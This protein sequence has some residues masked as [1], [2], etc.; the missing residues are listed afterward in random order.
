M[1]IKINPK[2][3]VLWKP[4]TRYILLT[5]GRG[6]AKSF[7]IGL[8]AADMMLRNHNWKMLFTRYTLSS[9]N[10]SVIPEF[11]EKLSI[12]SVEEEFNL[13]SSFIT[14][15]AT[16]SAIIFSGIKTSSGNQ[17][18]K[19]KSIPALNVFIVDEAEEF[20]DE[21]DFNTIDESIRMPNV[22][23]IVILVMNPQSVEHW[24]WKRWFEKSHVMEN[25]NGHQ[26]PIS[27]HEDL[28]HIHTTYLDNID[29]LNEDYVNKINQ[30][31]I[32]YPDAYAHR[33]LGKW[34]DKKLGVIFPN[35]IEGE[36]DESFPSGYGLDF[37]FYPDPL[38]LVKVSVD[39]KE[40]KIY[41][42]E[43]IYKQSLTYEMV[44]QQLNQL[45]EANKMIIADTSEPRLTDALQSSG[46]NVH[47]ADKG[48]GSI[49][50]G[51]KVINDYSLI[52]DSLSYN[53]KYE[54][55]NYVWNDRKS[56]TP[57]DADNHCFVGETL[58][59]TNKGLIEISKIIPNDY[60]LTSNG[61]QKV[62]IKH[63]NGK[64]QVNKYVL[65][66]DT[67]FVSLTCTNNHL[68]KTS[69][70]WKKVSELKSGMTVYL[71]KN[72]MQKNTHCIQKKGIFQ[73][74]TKE[75]T[76][77]YGNIITEKFQKVTIFITRTTTRIITQLIT[78][79]KLNP[80]NIYQNTGKEDMMKIKNG[81]NLFKKKELQPLQN[82]INQKQGLNGIE[83]M[84][85]KITLAN[86]IME[87]VHVFFAQKFIIKNQQQQNFAQTIASQL[88]EEKTKLITLK[89]NVLIAAQNTNQINT[90][91]KN[92]VAV[93]VFQIG[94]QEVYD[95]TVE[96]E[97]EYFA[98]GILVHNCIDA[99]RYVAMR[100]LQGSDLLAFN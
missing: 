15:K 52:V 85:E 2:Y 29:N 46:L 88:I 82:G 96:N 37:G 97:H 38:A 8:W 18:A 93:N 5:G 87:K 51:I 77:K 26:V 11:R 70:G 35:W 69:Q 81:L 73:E 27:S 86:L 47:K 57:I 62:L 41:I 48:A 58:V 30:M 98:N 53:L 25:I 74:A 83:N 91:G 32:D 12:L 72:L 21:R 3:E 80:Q 100:L 79:K 99:I 65:Q 33:F 34:L 84:Q 13:S 39:K 14:H 59:K 40:K 94:E 54:L 49:I 90:Q 31:A 95:L 7:T 68:I 61:Y 60:V 92:I 50:E 6:S 24:I 23:N 89:N 44:I 71:I 20:V 75:C 63:N 28:T 43:V 42:K 56:S 67:F 64:Q 78:L 17:T 19:L 22:P 55:R 1:Q 66:F 10:I 9:A 36:F 4:Q 16:K 76:L 45:V